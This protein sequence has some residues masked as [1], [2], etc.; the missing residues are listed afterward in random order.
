[1]YFMSRG[2]ASATDAVLA[3]VLAQAAVILPTFVFAKRLKLDLKETF[4]LRGFR[5]QDGMAIVG[6]AICT[7][8]LVLG[9]YRYGMPA[10]PKHGGIT[11]VMKHVESV[12]VP[13]LF[14]LIAV[15]PPICEELMCRG[16]LLSAFRP[17]RGDWRAV[18]IVAFLFAVMHLEPYRVPGTF[19]AGL[20]LGFVAVRTGSIFA[21]IFFHMVY[22]GTIFL[23]QLSVELGSRLQAV[24]PLAIAVAALGLGVA[25]W[26]F[27]RQTAPE[28]AAPG[29][30]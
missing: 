9:F 30:D 19:A 4:S 24:S 13:L 11:E 8:V 22:N 29:V 12:P 17:R 23:S 3:F 28:P 1:M 26:H 7:L 5:W 20:M 25:I 16:F 15:L 27:M 14:L 2:V 6:A 18:V 10:A 21:A